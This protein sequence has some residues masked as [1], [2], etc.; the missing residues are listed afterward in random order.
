MKNVL[1]LLSGGASSQIVTLLALIVAARIYSDSEFGAYSMFVSIVTLVAPVAALRYDLAIMLPREDSDAH[2]LLLLGR[3]AILAIS[4]ASA[5]AIAIAL[6]FLSSLGNARWW[7]L[8]AAPTIFFSAET[9]LFRYWLNRQGE[10]GRM[11]QSQVVFASASGVLQ[12]ALGAIRHLREFGLLMGHCLGSIAGWIQVVR[13]SQESIREMKRP[14]AGSLLEAARKYVKMPL[15]NG[16]N[17]LLDSLRLS[18]INFILAAASVA[19]LGQYG[20]AWRFT[21]APISL[22]N[23]AIG[24]V[25]FRSLARA[26]RGELTGLLMRTVAKLLG[27]GLALAI[28]IYA[29]SPWAFPFIL[30]KQWSDAG[31]YAKALSPWLMMMVATSPVSTVFIVTSRQGALLVA[32]AIYTIVP[33]S[34]MAISP[35]DAIVTIRILATIMMVSLSGV[36]VLAFLVSTK[37][38]RTSEPVQKEGS[39]L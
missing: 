15:L 16:T 5:A 32:S 29:A 2:T 36:T 3:R 24:Q 4:T 28:V 17:V 21:I 22:L 31:E 6:P 39:P 20:M 7:L 1:R 11:A 30:G 12:V 38:D 34:L 13:V 37:F 9:T 8:L 23:T 25:M 26:P 18:G 19:E 33:L 14:Q 35:W 10:F 27:L